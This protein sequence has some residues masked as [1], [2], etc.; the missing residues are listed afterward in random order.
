MRCVLPHIEA[1]AST[2]RTPACASVD[3]SSYFSSMAVDV[4]SGGS[5]S[6]DIGSSSTRDGILVMVVLIG[7]GDDAAQS[8]DVPRAQVIRS[9]VESKRMPTE[10]T[11]A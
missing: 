8:R 11:T 5:S 9:R 4:L 1:A 7:V 6:F 2:A 10:C 3:N